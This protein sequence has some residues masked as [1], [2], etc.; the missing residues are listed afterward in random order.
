MY[1][2]RTDSLAKV[3]DQTLNELTKDIVISWDPDWLP[4]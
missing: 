1:T 4:A 3:E 2:N